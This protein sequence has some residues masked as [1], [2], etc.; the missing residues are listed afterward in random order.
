[1]S[2]EKLTDASKS[3]IEENPYSQI[4]NAI[5]LHIKDNDAFRIYC[6]LSSKSRNWKVIKE[7]TNK[8]CGVGKRKSD[9]IWSYLKRCG[10]IEYVTEVDEETRKF[11]RTDIK[12][13]N[14]SIFN[15]EEPFKATPAKSAGMGKTTPALSAAAVSAAAEMYP[16]LNKDKQNRDKQ[17]KERGDKKKTKEKPKTLSANSFL[18][19]QKLIERYTAMNLNETEIESEIRKFRE[20]RAGQVKKQPEWDKDLANWLCKASEYKKQKTE[21]ADSNLVAKP[22]SYQNPPVISKAE[23]MLPSYQH[24][25]YCQCSKCF[26]KPKQA[27]QEASFQIFT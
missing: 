27:D 16:L 6:F 10:L 15:A 26:V 24:K 21:K 5:I 13:L 19:D 12:I 11:I 7:F 9:Y 23:S 8:V 4:L 25:E 2:I 3:F 20:S 14:G 22:V 17:K 1:M 18:I